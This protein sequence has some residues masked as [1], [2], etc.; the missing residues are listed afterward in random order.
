MGVIQPTGKHGRSGRNIT[1]GTLGA[2]GKIM[3]IEVTEDEGGIP[4]FLASVG[5]NMG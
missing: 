1:V 2:N 3:S 4:G 5:V